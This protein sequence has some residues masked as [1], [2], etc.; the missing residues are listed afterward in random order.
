MK[1]ASPTIRTPGGRDRRPCRAVAAR[2]RA[3]LSGAAAALGRG[4]SGGRRGRHRLADHGAVVVG[5][6]RPAGRGRE[7]AGRQQQYFDPGG[8]QFAARRLHAAVR[9]GVRGRQRHA[10]RDASV[11]PVARYRAGFRIDRFPAGDGR[12]P[13]A[14][15]QNVAELDRPRQGQSRQDQHGLVRHRLDLASGGRTVQDDDRRQHDSRALSRRGAD[16][17]RS[18]R[19]AG[20][21]RARRADRIAG[22]YPIGHAA[23]A[24]GAGK[25]RSD[26]LP[27]VPTIG[28]TVRG[29]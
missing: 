12:E 20:A 17:H 9:P 4:I 11:Q 3:S 29:I 26:A 21:G 22:P 8:G 14:A 25:T 2:P 5:T 1:A 6:A 27:D 10:V 18:H 19:R 24:G 28:E 13:V 23:R 16:G 15:G 7:Q